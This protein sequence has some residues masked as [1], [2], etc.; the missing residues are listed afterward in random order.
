MS[1]DPYTRSSP[2]VVLVFL[3]WTGI[4]AVFHNGWWLVTSVYLVV[5]AHLT[6]SRLVLVGAAQAVTALV[7]E[8]PA[9]V[10]ADIVSR[11]WSLVLS[12]VLMGAAMVATGLVTGFGASSPRRC[13]GACRGRSPAAPTSRG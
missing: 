11:K 2:D 8:V 5:D 4:R 3:R 12:H 6:A 13:C 9:G 10:V 7:C 1:R